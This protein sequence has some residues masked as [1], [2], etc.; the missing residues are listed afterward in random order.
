VNVEGLAWDPKGQRL[1]LGLRSPVV[2]GSALIVPLR[3]R[4]AGRALAADNVAVDGPALPVPLGGLGI[5][6]IEHDPASG[7][8][9]IIA[10]DPKGVGES[11]LVLWTGPGGTVRTVQDFSGA[12]KPEGVARATLGRRSVTVVLFDS[13]HFAVLP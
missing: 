10:G 6:G 7:A 5:R 1:L 8:F 12:D 13:S 3:M 4:D 2:D 9:Q 11:R